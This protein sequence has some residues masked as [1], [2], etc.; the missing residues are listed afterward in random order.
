MTWLLSTIVAGFVL[1]NISLRWFNAGNVFDSAFAL[2]HES[3]ATGK[4]W[5]LLTYGFLHD[6]RNLLHLLANL[7]AIY[8]LTPLPFVSLL[9][10]R[11]PFLPQ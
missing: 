3:V 6:P 1:Q 11:R 7:L 4:I 9:H 2:S 10:S 8:F 5:T